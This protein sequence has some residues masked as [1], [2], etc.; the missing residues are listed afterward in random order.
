[1]KLITLSIIFLSLFACKT[2]SNTSSTSAADA[3][4]SIGK[5]SHQYRATGCSTVVITKTVD[6]ELTLIP[7]VKIESKFDKDGLEIY[8][9]YHTLRMP[10]PAG[11]TAGIPAEITDIKLKK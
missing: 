3:N 5:I 8:F 7:N 11:C 2:S 9:N 10:Q 4:K 1:M 6:G